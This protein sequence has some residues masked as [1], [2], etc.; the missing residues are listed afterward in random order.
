MSPGKRE[1]QWLVM[2]R[3]LAIIRRAQRGPA[4]WEEMVQAVLA[5]E[6]PD[7]YGETEGEALHRRLEN[8]L[9]RIRHNL[10]VDLNFDRRAGGYVIDDTWMPLLDLPDEDLTTVAWLEQTFDHDSP[11][12][13]E[14]HAL[15]GRLRLYLG[16]ERLAAVERC[17][18]AL[19]VDIAQ[20]DRDH[21]SPAVW[22]GLTEALLQQ[23]RVEFLY[24]SPGYEDGKPRRHVADPYERR[25]DPARGHYYL[26]AY[27]RS[28]H[29]PDGSKEPRRYVTYRVGRILE[30]TVLPHK[31]SA[32]RPPAPLYVVQYELAPQVA[33]LGVSRLVWIQVEAVEERAD[34]SCLVSG[35]TGSLFWAVRAL[36]HYGPTCRVLGGPEMLREMRRIVSEMAAV[37]GL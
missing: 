36:L 15:T 21:I 16:L 7:A 13:D 8:D 17:R 37:Y 22:N 9:K 35:T 1:S 26:H 34:G 29:E 2:R 5:Q 14:V 28:V 10:M 19:T 23:R 31:L 25:F 32:V 6:G 12:H 4:S 20:R 24:L 33:R 27:C 3:C 18:T 30:L 11:Q